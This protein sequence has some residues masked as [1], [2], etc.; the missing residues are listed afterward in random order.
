MDQKNIGIITFHR[1]YNCGSMLQAY[2]L[3]TVLKKC[4]ST[5]SEIIDFS[6]AAQKRMYSIL[7]KPHNVK[8]LFRNILNLAFYRVIAAHNKDYEDFLNERLKCTKNR[9]STLSQLDENKMDFD[10][11]I[12]GSDQVWNT[13]AKDFDDAY[14]L[15]F[16][17]SKSKI[18]YAVS[19][20]ATNPNT[21]DNKGKYSS[22]IQSFDGV[23]VRERNA[24]KW[25]EE[26][27]GR[28]VEICLDPT[29]LVERNEWEV[30]AA[31]K[32]VEDKYLFW[33]AMTYKK[34]V[35][36]KVLAIGRKYNLPIYV[37][38]AKE[39]SRRGL[40]FHGIKL[41]PMGG[42]ASYLSMV[43]NADM[44]ITSSFHGTVFCNVFQKNFWYLNIHDHNTQDDRA[45]FLL[46]QLGLTD[47][48]VNKK[49]IMERDLLEKP[50]YTKHNVLKKE[51]E[52][53]I[54]YLERYVSVKEDGS[55]LSSII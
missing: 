9:Y 39:W 33:Y 23:S 6:N 16:V 41:A 29:L 27:S 42:P 49:E 31:D 10:L 47:R 5:D 8:E 46:Q 54:K 14:F 55:E 53:S 45:L 36:E 25:I 52:S 48:Y 40:F 21:S 20:G 13:R 34:D 37:L 32:E 3:Q 7:Y 4:F 2:A 24:K 12:T 38:D 50:N 22:F 30:L 44:V 19:L 17:N 43:K 1:S 35:M 18:A 51:I 15:P 26:L 11:Y 28:N